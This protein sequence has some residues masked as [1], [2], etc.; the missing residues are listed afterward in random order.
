MLKIGVTGGIGSGKSLVCRIF[1]LLGAPVYAADERAKKL[2]HSNPLLKKNIIEEFGNEAYQGGEY[3]RKYIASVV[4][5]DRRRL[6]KLNQ[7]IHPAVAVDFQQW[8]S[9]QQDVAYVIKEAAI[10]FES[11]GDRQLDGVLAVDAPEDIRIRRVSERDG[12][13]VNEIKKRIRSQWPADKIRALADWSVDNDNK[14]LILPAI[15]EIHNKLL[16]EG[17]RSKN[18]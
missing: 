7:L 15:L 17:K 8:S 2:V 11:G 16:K 10:I 3:N 4:F 14:K 1:S 18:E 9:N 5:K 6:E 13:E 12:L